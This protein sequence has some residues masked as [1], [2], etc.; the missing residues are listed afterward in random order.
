MPPATL[1][2]M[3][4][5]AVGMFVGITVL[6]HAYKVVPN[7]VE[8]GMSQLGRRDLRRAE[9]PLLPAQAGRR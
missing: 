1:V 3:A 6:A 2:T 9:P 8:S 5:L 7:P 4:T